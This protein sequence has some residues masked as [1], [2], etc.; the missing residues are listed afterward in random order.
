MRVWS[1]LRA[2]TS[3]FC[4]SCFELVGCL[5]K[6]MDVAL[7]PVTLLISFQRGRRTFSSMRASSSMAVSGLGSVTMDRRHLV[8]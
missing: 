4:S 8:S 7:S 6:K 1:D 3:S 5:G 2:G